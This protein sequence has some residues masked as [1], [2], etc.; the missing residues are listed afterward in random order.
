METWWDNS[1]THRGRLVWCSSGRCLRRWRPCK[2]R[3]LHQRFL[4]TSNVTIHLL[5]LICLAQSLGWSESCLQTHMRQLIAFHNDR[6]NKS[7]NVWDLLFFCHLTVGGGVPSAW[8]RSATGSPLITVY[9]IGPKSVMRGGTR[10]T[11]GAVLDVGICAP[12]E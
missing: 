11:K 4:Q 12:A 6:V 9:S 3:C 2:Y 7:M 1:A 8:Q 5:R 10:N